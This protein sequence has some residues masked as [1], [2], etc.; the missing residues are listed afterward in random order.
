MQLVEN[1]MLVGHIVGYVPVLQSASCL[2]SLLVIPVVDVLGEL[3][4]L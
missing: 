2:R 4:C 1:R 3:R